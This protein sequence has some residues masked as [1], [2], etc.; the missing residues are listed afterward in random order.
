MVVHALLTGLIRRYDF[1]TIGPKTS[2]EPNG[3]EPDI[4]NENEH[5][6]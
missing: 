2:F 6:H 1:E 4:G 3:H 5:E